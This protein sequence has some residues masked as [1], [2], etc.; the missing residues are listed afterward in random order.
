MAYE[1]TINSGVSHEL[2]RVNPVTLSGPFHSSFETPDSSSQKSFSLQYAS[3]G[4]YNFTPD[5]SSLRIFEA[6]DISKHFFIL[7]DI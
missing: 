7:S 5:F 1:V 6:L 2:R 4:H 3:V